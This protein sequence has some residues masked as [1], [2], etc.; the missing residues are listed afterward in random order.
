[1]HRSSP[2]LLYTS[3]H[4]VEEQP[5]GGERAEHAHAADQGEPT[6]SVHD[7]NEAAADAEDVGEHGKMCIRDRTVVVGHFQAPDMGLAGRDARGGL[8]GRNGAAGAVVALSLIH[9]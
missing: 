4:A 7:G 9:I 2:C 5:K 6:R 3:R 8:V 1:M